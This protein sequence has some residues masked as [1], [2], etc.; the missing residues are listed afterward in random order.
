MI[1]RMALMPASGLAVLAAAL[2]VAMPRHPEPMLRELAMLPGMQA[3]LPPRVSLTGP[4]GI[5]SLRN[6][7]PTFVIMAEEFGAQDEPITLRLE[8]ATNAQFLGPLLIDTSVSSTSTSITAARP[9]P[10]L[11]TVFWRAVAKTAR[12]DSVLSETVGPRV[13]AK[14]LRLI[15]PNGPGGLTL[16]ERRPRFVWSSAEVALPAGPWTYTFEL[17]RASGSTPV[18]RVAGLTDT[19]FTPPLDL[20]SNTSYRWAL[21]AQLTTGDE[22]RVTSFASFVVVDFSRPVATLL[23]QNFPNPFPSSTTMSTCLWFDLRELSTVRLDIFD[24]RGNLVR[25]LVPSAEVPAT[26]PAGRYGRALGAGGDSGCDQR[27]SWDGVGADGRMAPSGVYLARLMVG[28]SMI[29]RKMV[30]RGR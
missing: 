18:M 12:G 1:P 3:S 11:S 23:F 13:V 15:A 2:H 14:W 19:T 5:D 27:F 8:V 4:P 25:T 28:G 21:K 22:T 6:I 7:T 20:E 10:E 30:F 24:I 17:F 16:N 29:F 9:L 26:L